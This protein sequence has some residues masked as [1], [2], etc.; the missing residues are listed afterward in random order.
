MSHRPI[1]LLETQ[2]ILLIV[3][4]LTCRPGP[5]AN[6]PFILVLHGPV[7]E[8]PCDFM[9][10]PMLFQNV[11]QCSKQPET[12][13]TATHMPVLHQAPHVLSIE[14]ASSMAS[15]AG[16]IVER[17]HR[18]EKS[19]TENHGV[20]PGTLQR[21]VANQKP[22]QA[23]KTDELKRSAKKNTKNGRQSMRR[24]LQP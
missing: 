3:G 24:T 11:V 13:R 8:F 1:D 21:H 7:V 16:E 6:P 17:L 15:C 14:M 20:R 4:K 18:N 12:C 23:D 2:S 10:F 22:V 9:D 19:K 5:G